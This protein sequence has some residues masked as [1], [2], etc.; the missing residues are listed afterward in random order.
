MRAH[1]AHGFLHRFFGFAFFDKENHLAAHD[2]GVLK[3]AGL[4]ALGQVGVEIVFAR[5]L[6]FFSDFCAYGQAELNRAFDGG[7]IHHRQGAG[8]GQIGGAGLGIGLGAKSGA[9]AAEDFALRGELGVGF[10]ADDDFVALD[11]CAHG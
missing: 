9:G 10:K 4:V 7:L 8:Q 11:Q 2:H 6:A 5:K 1:Q 3:L